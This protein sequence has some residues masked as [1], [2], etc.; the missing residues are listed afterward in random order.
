MKFA[1][2]FRGFSGSPANLRMWNNLLMKFLQSLA[3]SLLL[4]APSGLLAQSHGVAVDHI[5]HSVKP[6]NN[7]YEY[8]NGEWLK[9]TV[10]P[11][12]RVAVG[13]FSIVADRTDKRVKSI[14]EN[15]EK[16][17]TAPATNERMIADLYHSYMDTQAIDAEGLKPLQPRMRQIDA[18][19][20]RKDLAR[21]LGETLRADVDALND[22]NFHTLNLFGLWVAPDFND[23]NHYTAYLL[24][25]G[26][27]LPNRAYYLDSSAHMQQ[28]RMAY[29]KHIA[30]MFELAGFDHAPE[31][32]ARVYRLE[33]ALAKTHWSLEENEDIHKANNPWTQAEFAAKA[34][35]LDWKT[36][37]EA[38]GLAHQKSFIVWEPS[39]FTG[40]AALVAGTPLDA[41][42]DW[43]RYHLIE[44]N[45]SG[46]PSKM[47]EAEFDFFGKTLNGAE[48]QRPRDHRGVMLVNDVLGDAV[49]QIYAKRYFSAQ[50]KAK[51]QALVANLIATYHKRLEAN[52]WL[53][54]S[55]KKEAIKKL[56]S[57]KVSVGYPDSWESYA[58]LEIK[59][60][61]LMGNLMRARLFHYR[62]EL[63]RIGQP[64]NRREWCMEPQTVNAVNLPLDNALNF[65][66]AILQPPF[67]DPKAPDAFNYGAI[68]SVIGH[69]ISHTFDA[70]GSTFDAEGQ[71]RNWW[72]PEDHA[73]FEAVT[74]A[75]ARQ[76]DQYS[77]FPGV[78]VN[79]KQTIDEDIAD[80]AGLSDAYEAYHLSLHGKKAPVVDGLTGD[81][82]FFLAFA[83][84]WAEK[85]RPA[86][87][88]AQ[89]VNDPH[90]PA[91]YR[92][93]T[94]R[95][96]NGWYKAF[97][98]KPGDKLY[99][100]PDQRVHIW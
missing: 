21:V 88:R 20:S 93:E 19:H 2:L 73:H 51:V 23:P 77:P 13:G 36:Y 12:D 7:F 87:L 50:E 59:A 53:A 71:V 100:R 5:D 95:N 85:V 78:H 33:L 16:A 49:G 52:T 81:Q 30:T 98:V 82:Q 1:L 97:D 6:G 94:V 42:K 72:T 34:P 11:P 79:G 24:Q 86:A 17:N 44:Q 92:A 89:I 25:G 37:F 84:N 68:G 61:D 76:Y 69:E 38:A 66:A 67:Y 41:W 43:L 60:E 9:H 8:A 75:L 96:I 3:V 14:I 32:A 99:L 18:I 74:A 39:A 57:L 80:V 65:P 56:D 62:Y 63:S 46:L 91:Q 55:T 22:T 35:G 10:I 15:A 45:A 64:V 40:E 4:C 47:A 70:E 54:P 29:Q 27:V 48:Q 26:L 90:A 31:R 83:Q 58:G 28:I